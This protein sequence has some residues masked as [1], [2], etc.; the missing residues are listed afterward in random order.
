[1]ILQVTIAE[2]VKTSFTVNNNSPIIQDYVHLDDHAQTT[3]TYDIN[4]F[5]LYL[6]FFFLEILL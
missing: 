5:L 2:V 6:F 1:M 4:L 3:C